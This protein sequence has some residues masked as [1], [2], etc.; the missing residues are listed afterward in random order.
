[1]SDYVQLKY[2]VFQKIAKNEPVD[3]SPDIHNS[4]AVPR[5]TSRILPNTTHDILLV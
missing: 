3:K 1:M 4:L 2:N 5:S